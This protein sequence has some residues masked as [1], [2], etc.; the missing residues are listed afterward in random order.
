NDLAR[1]H[2]ESLRGSGRASSAAPL[3]NRND[4]TYAQPIE[5]VDGVD[6]TGDAWLAQVIDLW[7]LK[8][9][10]SDLYEYRMGG[11]RNYAD[12]RRLRE[13]GLTPARIKA[14]RLVHGKAEPWDPPTRRA[15]RSIEA[16]LKVHASTP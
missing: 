2:V 16:T 15:M 3:L 7:G 13:A 1:F 9:K 6:V 4:P 10:P 8:V 12:V 14:L 11:A 5:R